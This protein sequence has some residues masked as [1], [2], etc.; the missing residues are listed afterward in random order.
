MSV[1][2]LWT[3]R[4]M[5]LFLLA[6]P[7]RGQY[8]R[9][10]PAPA[11]AGPS[12]D[13][14]VGYSYLAMDMPGP[15]EANYHGANASG[16]MYFNSRWGDTLEASYVR[17]P[18]EPASGHRRYV[19]SFMTGPVFIPLASDST[20]LLVRALAGVGLV[21]GGV[22][23]NQMAFR[24]WLARFTWAAGAGVEHK[25]SGPLGIR[26]DGDYFRTRFWSTSGVVQ[27]Q[28]DLRV[29]AGLVFR[30]RGPAFPTRD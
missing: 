26:I 24:G 27:P 29:S 5:L 4:T 19:M 9:T 17:A 15:T 11:A 18:K 2:R 21:D 12:C 16:T 30:F 7:L 1:L 14:S 25:L 3:E 6:S 13:V 22:P 20:Q 10:S 23:I 28:S 8:L